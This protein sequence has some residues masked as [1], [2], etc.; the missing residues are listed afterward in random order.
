MVF[1]VGDWVQAKEQVVEEDCPELVLAE[2]GGV[3]H[4]L[5]V[6]DQAAVNVFWERTGTVTIMDTD[7]LCWLG[8]ARTGKEAP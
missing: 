2:Q 6:I 4:V 8:D 3:G 1:S 7:L 5:E